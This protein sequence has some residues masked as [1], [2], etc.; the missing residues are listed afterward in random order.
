[1]VGQKK[2]AIGLVLVVAFSFL[3]IAWEQN[4]W[5]EDSGITAPVSGSNQTADFT[6]N[7]SYK[8]STANMTNPTWQ[9]STI[10]I[11]ASGTWQSVANTSAWIIGNDSIHFFADI[12]NITDGFNYAINVTLGNDTAISV[13][14]YTNFS[15]DVGEDA[16]VD[17]TGDRYY[18]LHV[19][20]NGIADNK[21]D[22]T[23]T[24]IYEAIPEGH[25]ASVSTS[26]EVTAGGG[27]PVDD[28][29]GMPVWG[30]IVIVII[31]LAAAVGGGAALKNR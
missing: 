2:L 30:W 21:A 14:N 27:V 18:D 17:V 29:G 1:M 16:K 6:I 15:V 9:N 24:K 23:V 3:V 7:I 28:D 8:N 12:S 25:D 11:N 19:I 10:F 26:G 5:N 20:L 4:G 31:I 13:M 22:I